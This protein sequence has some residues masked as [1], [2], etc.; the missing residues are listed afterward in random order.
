MKAEASQGSDP[1]VVSDLQQLSQSVIGLLGDAALSRLAV[2][3]LQNH[4]EAAVL[5]Q[6][7]L[8]LMM[9]EP[10]NTDGPTAWSGIYEANGLASEAQYAA[11]QVSDKIAHLEKALHE[12]EDKW[13]RRFEA[14]EARM[15]ASLISGP[16]DAF[17]KL[18]P[19]SMRNALAML[20]RSGANPRVE[21]VADIGALVDSRVDGRMEVLQAALA[22]LGTEVRRMRTVGESGA[23]EIGD[24]ILSSQMEAQ[25]FVHNNGLENYPYLF[26]SVT[27]FMEV[28]RQSLSGGGGGGDLL[29]QDYN[30]RR[31]GLS[32]IETA[33]AESYVNTLPSALGDGK[34]ANKLSK[35]A[36]FADWHTNDYSQTSVSAEL[37]DHLNET[38]ELLKNEISLN[39]EVSDRARHMLVRSVEESATFVDRMITW[40][41]E[42]YQKYETS[43]TMGKEGVWSLVQ[44]L[45]RAMFDEFNGCK[46]N[47]RNQRFGDKCR[48]P[49]ATGRVLWACFQMHQIARSYPSKGWEGH[50]TLSPAINKF[51]II[52]VSMK[53][54]LEILEKQIQVLEKKLGSIGHQ[55]QRA[56]G[57]ADKKKAAA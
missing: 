32:R 54:D 15:Q 31:L 23:I 42:F 1:A 19:P 28:L 51:L 13:E 57:A 50:S 22:Q 43:T 39:R 49:E 29:S 53:T 45:V 16:K 56:Q 55:A 47:V 11:I 6:N 5:K 20:A 34:T 27:T 4:V 17:D 46:T 40:I 35:C 48:S 37:R 3:T 9:G 24:V 18:L 8:G 26:H 41:S 21:P 12:T 10:G 38:V 30:E 25:T 36:T 44:F 7:M 33:V 14:M 52:K 2:E